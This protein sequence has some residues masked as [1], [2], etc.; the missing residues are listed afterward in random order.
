MFIIPDNS[1]EMNFWSPGK[2]IFGRKFLGSGATVFL[3]R[4]DAKVL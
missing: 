4:W 3:G 1:Q 2:G